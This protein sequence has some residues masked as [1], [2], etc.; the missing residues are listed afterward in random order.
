LAEDTWWRSSAIGILAH[1]EIDIPVDKRSGKSSR[2][3]RHNLS[4]PFTGTG[5]RD[6][7]RV[8]KIGKSEFSRSKEPGH[9]KSR[10]PDI[11]GTVH[12]RRTRGNHQRHREKS[13]QGS[14]HRSLKSSGYR[15][16][17]TSGLC[18][19][20]S[21][22]AKPRSVGASCQHSRGGGQSHSGGQL[23]AR[24]RIGIRGIGNPVG[25][26]ILASQTPK[27][28]RGKVVVTGD[29]HIGQG[30]SQEG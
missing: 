27:P 17:G 12:L 26:C 15:D 16:P 22:N 11:I 28:R 25:V 14:I 19:L 23:S 10:N 9:R 21:R 2:K 3:P 13:R 7:A 4:R 24:R 8:G 20:K 5:V 18:I 29:G 1:R 6:L 30:L